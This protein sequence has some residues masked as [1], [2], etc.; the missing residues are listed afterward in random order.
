MLIGIHH[1]LNAE[2]L[3]V[4]ASMGHGDSLVVCDA[5]FPA[6]SVADSTNRDAPIQLA[7]DALT[8]LE[9][10]L[11]VFPIDTFEADVPPVLGMAVVGNLDEIP[12]IIAEAK[13]TLARSKATIELIERLA[14]YDA[15][16]NAYAVIRTT[17]RRHYGNFI[18]RKGV[19]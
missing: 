6:S 8:A 17:E 18:L 10:I 19:V 1:L 7:V 2:V 12:S 13:P 9:A 5:N 11:T 15:A 3:H 4:L 14:F 16:K